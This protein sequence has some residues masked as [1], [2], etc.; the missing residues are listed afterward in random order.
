MPDAKLADLRRRERQRVRQF[1]FARKRIHVLRAAIAKRN[2]ELA[3]AAR[4]G[5]P[6]A[7][8]VARALKS[9]GAH[10]DPGRPNRSRWLDGWVKTFGQ[11]WM[12]GQPY[13]GLGCW[14]WWKRAGKV[15]P[16]DTVSTVAIANR[17]R[18]GDGFVSVPFDKVRAGDLLVMN[19]GS[20]GPKH[21]GLARGP[22]RN[23]VFATVEANTSPSNSGSQANGGGCYLRTRPR[24]FI[25]S[26]ARP[27]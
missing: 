22:M 13:C 19:F 11:S 23:G 5:D 8:A 20:G 18:R 10:E 14:I 1:R 6:G 12:T 7:A 27:K 9:V 16:N 2:K 25:H 24:N 26:I 4:A 3:K 17:A 21:V 15:L